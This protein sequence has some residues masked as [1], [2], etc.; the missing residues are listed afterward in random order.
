MDD[1]KAI[2]NM[3]TRNCFMSAIDLIVLA[4]YIVSISRLFQKIFKFKWNDKLYCLP[5]SKIVLGLAKENSLN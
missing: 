3:V 5:A 2:I 4:Y 1:I